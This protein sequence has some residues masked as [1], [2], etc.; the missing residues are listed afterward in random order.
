M[1]KPGVTFH[2]GQGGL[3]ISSVD[4]AR[5]FTILMNDG[6][7][8]GHQYLSQNALTEM[9]TDQKISTGKGFA[10]CIGIRKSKELI[11]NR[12]MYFHN[13]ASYGI[14]SLMAFDPDDKSGIV[15]ITSGAYT[16]RNDNT[17]F[18]VCDDVLNYTYSH[19][20]K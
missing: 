10:Q 18:A 8:E 11:K 1:G 5:V 2:L 13:G 6:Q 17:V 9:L 19:I 3:L 12:E 4:L 14:F 15:I 7:Y 16:N 20:L